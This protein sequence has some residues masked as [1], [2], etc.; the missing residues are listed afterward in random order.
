[1]KS[2]ISSPDTFRPVRARRP[3]THVS[4]T[5][6]LAI[7][8]R[9]P[10]CRNRHSAAT[11]GHHSYVD[12]CCP[13]H[14]HIAIDYS[15]LLGKPLLHAQGQTVWGG[16]IEPHS[17]HNTRR[18]VSESASASYRNSRPDEDIDPTPLH[19]SG[20]L[21]PRNTVVRRRT[22]TYGPAAPNSFR[23]DKT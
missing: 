5:S 9:A 4:K 23:T 21:A 12:S 6:N 16:E 18:K 3:G 7:R 20:N 1:M 11:L 19:D 22:T 10:L 15:D 14:Q 8:H 17:R 13:D 2:C